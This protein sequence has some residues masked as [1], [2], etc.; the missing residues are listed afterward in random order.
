MTAPKTLAILLS[1]SVVMAGCSHLTDCPPL[2]SYDQAF[3]NRL[4]DEVEKLDGHSALFEVVA[5]Y[6]VLREQMRA[7][8]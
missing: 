7:C 2:K 1:V 6:M 3:S 8:R 4:A 5:D